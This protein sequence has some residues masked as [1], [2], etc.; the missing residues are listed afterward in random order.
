M[1]GKS[2]GRPTPYETV[3]QSVHHIDLL[4]DYASPGG[5]GN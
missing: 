4:N 2:T 3:Q 5:R 1:R